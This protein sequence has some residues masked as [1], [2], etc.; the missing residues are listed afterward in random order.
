[1]RILVYIKSCPGKELVY[2]KH[3]HIRISGY[4]DSGYAG[5]QE[6]RKST[7]AI[8]LLLEEIWWSGKARN[9]MCLDSHLSAEA[10]YRV[11]THTT[12]EMVWL[13]NL[14]ME[15]GFRQPVPMHMH[16]DYQYAIYIGQNPVFHERTKH[17]EVDCHFVGDAWT[18]KVVMF[19]FTPSSK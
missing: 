13:Q 7:T 5:D 15:L 18:N 19:Q 3:G 9:K 8:A 6:D 12:C 4:S 1:M 10:K 17:F 2:M 16:C 14:L 11:M